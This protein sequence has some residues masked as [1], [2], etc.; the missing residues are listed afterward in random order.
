MDKKVLEA[1]EEDRTQKHE[2]PIMWIGIIIMT[3]V[4]ALDLGLFEWIAQGLHA[5]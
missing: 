2:Y 5:K 3:V 4:I 1:Y